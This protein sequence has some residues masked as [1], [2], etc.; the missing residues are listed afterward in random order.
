M[1]EHHSRSYG[2][3]EDREETGS[4]ISPRAKKAH[5]IERWNAIRTNVHGIAQLEQI[6]SF[7]GH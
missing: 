5:E 3:E 7:E 4:A 2:A 1:L 6:E